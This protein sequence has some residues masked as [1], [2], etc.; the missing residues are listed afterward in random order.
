MTLLLEGLSVFHALFW[1]AAASLLHTYLFYPLIMKA[2]ARHT[3]SDPLRYTS[4]DALPSIS[5]LMAAHNEEAV[6]AEKI[7]SLLAQDYP[8]EKVKIYIGSDN[9]SDKTNGIIHGYAL[10]HPQIQLFPFTTRQ[11]KPSIINQLA[12]EAI[13]QSEVEYE[14]LYM[15]TDAS[16]MLSPAVVTKLASHFKDPQIGLVDAHMIY[17]GIEAAGISVSEQNYLSSEVRLKSNESQVWG[18]MIGPFGGCFM[19]RSELFF[20]VPKNFLVDDFFLAMKVLQRGYKVINDLDAKCY[21]SVS[22]EIAE[23]FKRKKRI[24]TGN[25]QNL[26]YFK[27]LLNPFKS[28]G[29]ALWSHKVLRWLGPFFILAMVLSAI[30]LA[31]LG[32][33]FFK[34]VLSL[35]GMILLVVPALDKLLAL[36][37]IHFSVFRNIRYFVMM[38]VA[39]IMGFFKYMRGVK[40]S[41]WEPTKRN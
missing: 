5:I 9:S 34:L 27:G 28:L 24:S 26:N 40:S 2:L 11:G 15:L 7:D 32:S 23:E 31:V 12:Q 1:I 19:L 25:Y 29:F 3:K 21:E 14:H 41:A 16:V 18:K 17:I 35:I 10:K 13:W 37:G 33:S 38:N 4:E 20:P 22:H 30:V 8:P 6:I 39:L 36:G